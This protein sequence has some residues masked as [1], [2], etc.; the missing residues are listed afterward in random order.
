MTTKNPSPVLVEL[1]TSEGCS[2]CPPADRLLQQLDAS[3]PISGAQIIVL[4]EHVDYWNSIGWK[5]PF[6]SSLFSGRQAAYASHFGLSSVY[7]PQMVVDGFAELTGSDKVRANHAIEGALASEKVP[8]RLSSIVLNGDS[9][10][11]HVDVDPSKAPADVYVALALNRAESNVKSGENSGHHLTHV[12]VVQQLQKVGSLTTE[13]KFSQDVEIRVPQKADSSNLRAIA[14]VQQPGPGKVL[15]AT[16]QI[17][18][19]R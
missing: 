5:D 13:K 7:T 16:L 12:A 15:G 3:Q 6:S 2:S 9:V 17:L 1:F 18:E 8:V 10:R 4:S 11:A 19:T 14:F